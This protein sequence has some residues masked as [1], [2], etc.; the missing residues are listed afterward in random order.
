MERSLLTLPRPFVSL[1]PA[2]DWGLPLLA[3]ASAAVILIACRF[4]MQRLA[5]WEAS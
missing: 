1:A 3:L 2:A 5:T 4:G